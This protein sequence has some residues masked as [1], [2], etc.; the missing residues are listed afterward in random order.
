MNSLDGK[1]ILYISP[2]FFGYENTIKTALERKFGALVDFYDDRPSSD[3]L[4]KIFIRLNFKLFVKRKIDN[5]YTSIFE[6]I[7][8]MSYDCIFIVSPET[9]SYKEL[10]TLKTLQSN[11]QFI[12]Y[13]WDSFD[14]K[15]SFNTI[16]LF[17]RVVTFDHRDAEKYNLYFH[18]LFYVE[19]YETAISESDTKYD[20]CTIATAHSD[21]YIVTKKVK[22]HL[23][24]F[25]LKMFIFLYLNNRLMYWGRRIFLKKY[26]YGTISD[27]SF[28]PLSQNEIVSIISQSKAILDINHPAQFGLTMRTFESL[29]A[30]KKL[31][32]TNENIKT[33]DFYDESNILVIDRNNPII[34][35]NFLDTPYQYLDTKLYQKY[36]LVNWIK[37][38]F[39][40]K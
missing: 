33:Y 14:N 29:G 7:K 26:Q 36:S 25:S 8:D 23:E 27:F 40:C 39:D 28:S 18:P 31:I 32:T 20:V 35:I 30:N 10:N 12:L 17:D 22:N 3:I 5:Y 21:R 13:M 1:R 24:Q 34:D 37:F 16:H 4:T 9:L 15:N 11:A 19:N 38:V 6:T 2:K